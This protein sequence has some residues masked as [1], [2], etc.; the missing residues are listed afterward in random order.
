M[1][2]ILHVDDDADD[3]E[4][5]RLNLQRLS[6][7][8]D[9]VGTGSAAKALE[10]LEKHTVDCLVSDYQMPLTD[11]LQFLHTLRDNG[12]KIPFIF[13]TG[14][15]SEAV[16]AEALR[17]GADDYFTKGEG[18]VH[19]QRLAL[20]IR[21][22]VAIY[23]NEMRKQE[24]ERALF[25]ERNFVSAILNTAGA[26]V[27]VLDEEGHIVRFNK[28]CEDLTGYLGDEVIGKA[29]W[30]LF[31][32][33]EEINPVKAVF[34]KLSEGYFPSEYKNYWL[35]K[36]GEKRLIS[37]ANT[38]LVSD[39]GSVEYVIATGLDV[40]ERVIAQNIIE[41]N[42]ALLAGVL[43]SSSSSIMAFRSIRDSLGN[44]VDF[45][46]ILANSAVEETF[47]LPVDRIIGERLKKK[48]P[49]GFVIQFFDKFIEVVEQDKSLEQEYSYSIDG[50][51]H[52]FLVTA[53]KLGDGFAVTLTDISKRKAAERELKL[54][55]FAMDNAIDELFIAGPDARYIYANQ[56]ACSSLGYSMEE[57]QQMHVWD[58]DTAIT[59]E[60]WPESW[61][62]LKQVNFIESETFLLR[63]DGSLQPVELHVNYFKYEGEEYAFGYIN[64]ISRL[65]HH[66]NEL[67]ASRRQLERQARLLVQTNKELEAFAYTVSHD[68]NAPLH[69]ISSYS[70]LLLSE[71]A[72]RLDDEGIKYLKQLDENCRDLTGLVNSVLQFSRLTS[73]T[74]RREKI[75]ISEIARQIVSLLEKDAPEREVEFVI[76]DDIMAEGDNQLMRVV[77]ENLLGNAW[78]YT[79][80]KKKPRIEVGEGEYKGKAAY[81][82]NDN[83]SGF[84]P[85]F[86]KE[87]FVPFR[88]FHNEKDF[89]GCGIGLATVKRIIHRHGGRVWAEGTPGRGATFFFTLD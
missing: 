55:K 34:K 64:D 76:A 29:V 61:S 27:V 9:L 5:I 69:R 3:R 86:A 66:Q 1:I 59:E 42:Q 41:E 32:I 30:D 21:K 6:E 38:A 39:D 11:G 37:W 65:K 18:L 49:T 78:K 56:A 67:E 71:H 87:L 84:N 88:R 13:L 15:G 16:A 77:L 36:S 72:D 83:G 57:M 79:A 81:Y 68:L 82:V 24:A 2:H 47:N 62:W 70:E 4:L 53:V 22:V 33:P 80:K 12:Q 17:A 74:I 50:V 8:F 7:D 14:Q 46:W 23:R 63:K 43:N 60:N 54:T 75:N 10:Y 35:T 40:T 31:L 58:T 28:A 26:L 25:E 52:Y 48:M 73:G 51:A 44:I 89:E 85:E 20:S 45:A 19:Y